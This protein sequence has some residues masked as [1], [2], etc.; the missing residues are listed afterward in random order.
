M[1]GRPL[2]DGRIDV[3]VTLLACPGTTVLRA[4]PGPPGYGLGCQ[5]RSHTVC[6]A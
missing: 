6:G 2:S 4:V 3:E 5:V 1:R